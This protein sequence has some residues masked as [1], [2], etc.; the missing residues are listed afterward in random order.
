[1]SQCRTTAH[2]VTAT[3]TNCQQQMSTRCHLAVHA[4]VFFL[5]FF[6]WLWKAVSLIKTCS[7][8]NVGQRPTLSLER[9]PTASNR[10]PLQSRCCSCCFSVVVESSQSHQNLQLSEFG[11]TPH[12]VSGTCPY[13]Q[14]QMT[15]V[16]SQDQS[17]AQQNVLCLLLLA[18]WYCSLLF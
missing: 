18:T 4:V 15:T 13:C 1:M 14:Q 11:T 17:A 12:P 2:P 7:C 6:Q 8:L 9:V 5:F 10:R 16:T 3:C